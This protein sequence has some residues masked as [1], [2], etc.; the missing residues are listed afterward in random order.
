M[1]AP[2]PW[3][4]LFVVVG[5]VALSGAGTVWGMRALVRGGAALSTHLVAIGA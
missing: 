3:V 1:L 2:S 5:A 4:T